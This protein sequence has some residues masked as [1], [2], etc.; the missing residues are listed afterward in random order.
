MLVEMWSDVVCPW[1]A[2]GR[3]RFAQAVED[4]AHRD[5]VEFVVRSFELD[6]SAPIRRSGTPA[7]NIAAKYGMSLDEAQRANDHVAE[8][9][10]LDGLEF[11][12]DRAKTGNTFD[13]HRLTH[14]ALQRGCQDEMVGAL[15]RGYFTDGLAVGEPGELATLAKGVGLAVGEVA[16]LLEGDA[17][18]DEVRADESRAQS[19]GITGVPFFLIE[20]RFAIPGAQPVERFGQ[21]LERA[22]EKVD[23]LNG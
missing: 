14:L 6:P 7:E 12:F 8:V 22:W 5:E 10:A 11:N 21:G 3:A 13:A 16:D 15:M 17:Y 2:I 4:F 18:A 19:L 23:A 9:A 1:C 20:G